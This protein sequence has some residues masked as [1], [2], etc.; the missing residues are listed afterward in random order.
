LSLIVKWWIEYNYR[1]MKNCNYSIYQIFI[2]FLGIYI[3]AAT[4]YGNQ[5]GT[6]S[7]NNEYLPLS[8]TTHRVSM[9]FTA[10]N[11]KTVADVRIYVASV[12]GTSPVYKIGIQDN[13]GGIPSGT[14]LSFTTAQL[15]SGWNIID[16]P[17]VSIT[18]GNVYHIVIEYN[19]GT[20]D[21]NNYINIG[22]TSPNLQLYPYDSSSDS[23]SR[24]LY[25]DNNNWAD[26]TGDNYN[27]VYVLRFTDGT[28][29]GNPIAK[30]GSFPTLIVYNLQKVGEVWYISADKFVQDISFYVKGGAAGQNLIV[31]LEDTANPGVDIE[32]GTIASGYIASFTLKTYSFSTIRKLQAGKTYRIYLTSSTSDADPYYVMITSTEIND[33]LYTSL[34]FDGVVAR[35][36][37]DSGSGWTDDNRRDCYFT[38][39]KY[40]LLRFDLAFTSPQKNAVAFTGTVLITAI[41]DGGYVMTDFDA[42]K[43]NV[44]ITTNSPSYTITGLSLDGINDNV[45]SSTLDFVGGVATLVGT[46]N[47]IKYT[48]K[49]GTF[50][51]TA[52]SAIDNKTGTANVTITPGSTTY[53]SV[54]L[55]S[56]QTDGISFQ[57]TNI[58]V[59]KDISD[60]TVTDYDSQGS[61]IT[62][63]VSGSGKLAWDAGAY[64]SNILLSKTEFVAG[65]LTLSNRLSYKGPI[66]TVTLYVSNAEGK[67]GNAPITINIGELAYFSLTL[68]SPQKN[69]VAFT[70]TNIIIA[71][72]IGDNVITQ[73]NITGTDVTFTVS[74]GGGITNLDNV[75]VLSKTRFSNGE[76]NLT[77]LITYTGIAQPIS[78]TAISNG[79]IG[80]F[81]L[82]II[83]GDLERYSFALTSPQIDGIAF[84]GINRITAV[85]YDY[86]TITDYATRYPANNVV[87]TTTGAGVISGLTGGNALVPADFVNGVADVTNKLT[88]TGQA[89][90]TLTFTATGPGNKTGSQP[91]F[92]NIGALDHFRLNFTSPQK[93]RYNFTGTNTVTAEDIG[94]NAIPDYIST[95][96]NVTLSVSGT[97]SLSGPDVILET[98]MFNNGVATITPLGLTYSGIAGSVTLTATASSKIGTT[99]I[100]IVAGDL[101]H[102]N[103][104]LSSPQ[105]DGIAFTGINRI[106][107]VDFD[108]NPILDYNT[109]GTNVTLSTN[110]SSYT[111][112]GLSGG[113]L[114]YALD[115]T[116]G[117]YDLSNKLTYI[118]RIGTY[119]F[120]ASSAGKTGNANVTIN[121]G[122]LDH[123]G[124]SLTSPQTNRIGFTGTNTVIAFDIGNNTL[125]TLNN[126]VTLSVSSSPQGNLYGDDV[127]L[128]KTQFSAGVVTIVSLTYGGV[129]GPVTIT[130][131][132]DAKYGI[133]NVTINPGALD[134]FKLTLTSPQRIR[135]PFTGINK[136]IAQDV[137]NNTI[138]TFN[139][140]T[141]NV[142]ITISPSILTISGL[143]GGDSL[144]QVTDF[145]NGV[146]NLTNKLTVSGYLGS[147]VRFTF[148]VTGLSSGKTN[149]PSPVVITIKPGDLDHFD[150]FI[151]S[152]QTNGVALTGVNYL[153]AKDAD[154]N[155][156]T[157]YTP[158]ETKIVI[159][160][161]SPRYD[162]SG[163]GDVNGDAL[164]PGT[165]YFVNG[166]ATLTDKLIY[167]GKV[168]PPQ[169]RFYAT[170]DGNT[171]GTSNL[172]SIS[173]GAFHHL[174]LTLS[175]P[176]T[177][178][179]AF[180]GI[181][182]ITAFDIGNNPIT[183]FNELNLTIKFTNDKGGTITGLTSSDTLLP[184]DFVN[185]TSTLTDKLTYTGMVGLVRFTA[186]A[187]DG[188]FT[189]ASVTII[190]GNL[191]HFDITLTSP[192]YDGVAFIGIN[193]IIAKDAGNNIITDFDARMNP[194]SISC[195]NITYSSLT[196]T[197]SGLGSL[198]KNTLNQ[199]IDFINGIATLTNKMI[200][201]GAP[202]E[203]EFT[204]TSAD[205]KTGKSNKI[206]IYKK[207]KV[208][209]LSTTY[210]WVDTS[211]TLNVVGEGF[212][213]VSLLKLDDPDDTTLSGYSIPTHTTLSNVII[214][215]GISSG[216]YNIIATNPAGSN[217]SSDE[218]I[219]ILIHQDD[220]L[221][222]IVR[223][224]G[225]T[226]FVII[227]PR[228]FTDDTAVVISTLVSIPQIVEEANRKITPATKLTLLPQ[229]ENSI[230]EITLTRASLKTGVSVTLIIP[231]SGIT[232]EYLERNLK[233]LKLNIDKREWEIVP[234]ESIDFLNKQVK[235]S[236][237]QFSIFRLGAQLLTS[238]NLSELVVFP[239]PVNFSKA[240]R[241]TIKFKNLTAD[242][243]IRIYT[244]SGE[245]VRE[246]PPKTYDGATVN[247][248]NTGV[249]EWDGTN[250]KGE[251]VAEGIYFYLITDKAGH[252]K[253]GKFVVIK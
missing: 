170:I 1:L 161:D 242:P 120:T 205:S 194:V 50:I 111:I 94:N 232:E 223:T 137:D 68:T 134:H 229:L 146:A 177:N 104:I 231:Y 47:N 225:N 83:A 65:I 118:G 39:T 162:I 252:R 61:D 95:G 143:S 101:D 202:G 157:D 247:D 190:S 220:P 126:D 114:I 165:D 56:P 115:F 128:E 13:S 33:S 78:I 40:P 206:I 203:I 250:D 23:N 59:P 82:T 75:N 191:D 108:N 142:Q 36:Q 4:Y 109:T 64:T 215:S 136:I 183:N 125:T 196:G 154:N 22:A 97:G 96:T 211:V 73:Y 100:T 248:G 106:T 149:Y 208:T 180:T 235:V 46:G 226:T 139:A 181:N 212:F 209:G 141:D 224:K 63:T 48:G 156:I 218:K 43:N 164:Y 107:A 238:P 138:T 85:D 25:D 105:I 130:A 44:I 45:L 66:G 19:S 124:L 121:I 37:Y 186:R 72:D 178:A 58:V 80:T 67:T 153:I 35:L 198:S 9:R 16:I 7:A 204:A 89:G 112:S 187:S 193:Y 62:L 88:Y 147:T 253:S 172:V 210:G 184:S 74:S 219:E 135:I 148:T 174:V 152:P 140:A 167:I 189:T 227:P 91:V 21:A 200:Y 150:F 8:S 188:K 179:T 53:F 207:P 52:K 2:L 163:L 199:T 171:L 155:K 6:L 70:G 168:S 110:S 244:I 5:Y 87:I 34:S 103:L 195:N 86:N 3:N 133:A 127:I 77:N 14:Y 93:N 29:E 213:G 182:Y 81:S 92:M 49:T 42:S 158:G 113:S 159:T 12:V 236:I 249:A 197:I 234:G 117:V 18:S 10:K 251:K 243:T 55:T 237:S 245:L 26:D 173:L 38:F 84:T 27:P 239:N 15:S 28:S 240:V 119:T 17:D 57:G 192:Q 76:A 24:C 217:E 116:N 30:L 60:N 102:F 228:A 71:R 246:I 54:S 122:P 169:Y 129:A 11:S 233:I 51:F 166:E 160:S 230:R 216:R 221:Q 31:H 99:I 176:Q 222:R 201:T 185:G 69:R 20:I 41:A 175:S 241:G 90:I 132:S 144:I 32:S 151:T 214:P 123:F 145:S 98:S 131:M 79:K